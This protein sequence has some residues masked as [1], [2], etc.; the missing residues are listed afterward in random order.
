MKYREVA[1]R[2]IERDQAAL[3]EITNSGHRGIEDQLAFVSGRAHD[4][5]AA[6]ILLLNKLA[7]DEDAKEE[8][9]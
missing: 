3:D 8:K 2:L 7:D 1:R 5:A 4:T 9:K 6:L